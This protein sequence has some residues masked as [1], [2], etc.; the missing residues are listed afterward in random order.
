MYVVQEGDVEVVREEEGSEVALAVLGP[1][2]C[3]GEMAV[4]ERE[5]R[6]ATVRARGHARVLTVDKKTL[7]R[8]F[9]KDPTL[10]LNILQTLSRRVRVLDRELAETRNRLE[11]ATSGV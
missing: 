2:E 11:R 9:Q 1:G 5:K 10:A 6:S 3:F 4:F 7:L 8:R